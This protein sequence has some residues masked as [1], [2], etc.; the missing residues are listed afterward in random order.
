MPFARDHGE[1]L[2]GLLLRSWSWRIQTAAKQAKT[3]SRRSAEQGP[4]CDADVRPFETLQFDR[5]GGCRPSGIQFLVLVR[6]PRTSCATL[7]Q[8]L[9]GSAGAT[10]PECLSYD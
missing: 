4:L 1:E 10:L 7:L 5:S 8:H 9:H 2:L 3:R 6:S